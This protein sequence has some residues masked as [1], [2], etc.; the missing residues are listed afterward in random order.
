LSIFQ[1]AQKILFLL[2]YHIA[3]EGKCDLDRFFGQLVCAEKVFVL[4]GN[5]IRGISF[6]S[7][8][9][10]FLLGIPGYLLAWA[11]VQN[12]TFFLA[13]LDRSLEP[14]LTKKLEF[15][16]GGKLSDFHQVEYDSETETFILHQ[17]SCF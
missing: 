2:N 10:N 5:D 11:E 7:P 6:F 1:I 17:V 16:N 15:E 3:G 9:I 8:K 14:W 13:V 4:K 12:S